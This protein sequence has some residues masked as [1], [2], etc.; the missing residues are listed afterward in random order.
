M[1]KIVTARKK[2]EM[3]KKTGAVR[4]FIFF[5]VNCANAS[6]D[7][8]SPV[9]MRLHV[10]KTRKKEVLRLHVNLLLV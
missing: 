8:S 2:M 10:C 6:V 9:E 4:A 1:G 7:C 3:E 5:G